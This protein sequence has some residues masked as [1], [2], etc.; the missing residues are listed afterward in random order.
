[1]DRLEF[2]RSGTKAGGPLLL[3]IAL[4]I[5]LSAPRQVVSAGLYGSSAN[6]VVIS[7]VLANEPGSL[8]KLEWVELHN[9]DSLSHN[10]EGWSF[11]CKEDTT[12]F[13]AN[14]VIPAKGCLII[15][16]QLVSDPLDSVSF[17]GHWGDASGVW[18]DTPD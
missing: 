3:L 17:E 13:A 12:L 7:E 4:F 6:L 1:M 8:T 14:T 9:A 11:V 2:K 5:L 16:R 15:A 10:L 18:G